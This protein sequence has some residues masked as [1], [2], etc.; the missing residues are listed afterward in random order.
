MPIHT[1]L[2]SRTRCHLAP[3]QCVLTFDD[4][5]AGKVTEDLLAVLHQF[6]VKACFCLVGSQVA[7][8]PEQTRA[9]STAGHLL[10]NHSFHHRLADLWNLERFRLDLAR[11]DEAICDALGETRHPLRWFRPPFGLVTTAVG[12]VAKTRHI[13]PVTHFMIDPWLKSDRTRRP[14]KWMI[15][16][17]KRRQGG[18]YVLHDGMMVSGVSRLVRGTPHRSWIPHVVHEVM[19]KLNAA[20]FEFPDP[21]QVFQGGWR[22]RRGGIYHRDTEDTEFRKKI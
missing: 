22:A 2:I 11:C 18:I 21:S 14:A 12:E 4:G 7:M 15:E 10:V 19:G 16:D 1:I 6:G 20:G 3:G 8:R 9:I 5:P 17:A 13:L